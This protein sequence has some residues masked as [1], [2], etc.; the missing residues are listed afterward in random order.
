MVIEVNEEYFEE[1]MKGLGYV[2]VTH[3]KDCM[4]WMNGTFCEL[5]HSSPWGA[6]DYCSEGKERC[7]NG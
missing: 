6:D 2:K 1:Y 4:Y 5:S 3:C 7:A